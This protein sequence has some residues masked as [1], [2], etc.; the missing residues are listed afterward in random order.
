M[1][2]F[3]TGR[4]IAVDGLKETIK[5]FKKSRPELAKVATKANKKLT[6]RLILPEAQRNWSSQRIKPS[7]AAKAVVAA[8]GQTWAGVRVRYRDETFPYGA[9]VL[10]GSKQFAQFRPWIGNQY[11]AGGAGGEKDFIVDPAVRKKGDRFAGEMMKSV[12]DAMV[13][14]IRKA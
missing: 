13:D 11:T 10:F 12:S 2:T 8:A 7:V 6:Q 1:A 14:A 4:S 5:G 9:G 3:V